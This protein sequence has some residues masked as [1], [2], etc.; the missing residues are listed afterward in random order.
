MAAVR[1]LVGEAAVAVIVRGRGL[2]VLEEG[3][4]ERCIIEVID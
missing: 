3:E 1:E 2:E 4:A